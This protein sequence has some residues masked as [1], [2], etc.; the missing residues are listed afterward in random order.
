MDG[1]LIPLPDAAEPAT[2]TPFGS[3]VR[4]PESLA[5]DR[6]TLPQRH[7][8]AS[9]ATLNL[10]NCLG[11]L[12]SGVLKLMAETLDL[13]FKLHDPPNAFEIHP[14]FDKF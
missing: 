6:N 11:N 4:E 13:S 8:V 7:E 10:I 5:E 3:D 1:G 12:L 2:T 14:G 9:M